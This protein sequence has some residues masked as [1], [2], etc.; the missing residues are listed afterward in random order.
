MTATSAEISKTESII[1]YQT[2]KIFQ[3]HHDL[4]KLYSI[5]GALKHIYS[6]QAQLLLKQLLLKLLHNL[7]VHALHYDTSNHAVCTAVLMLF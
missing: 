5:Y 7:P 3:P 1:Q 4:C 6:Q 2:H